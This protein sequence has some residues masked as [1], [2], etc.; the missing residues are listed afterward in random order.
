M[1]VVDIYSVRLE[2]EAARLESLNEILAPQERERAMRFRFAEHQREYIVCRGTLREVLA[3]YVEQKPAHIEFNYN[4]HGKPSVRDSQRSSEVRFNVSHSKGW[5]LLAVTRGSEVGIDIER[6]D[7]RFAADQIPER[8]FSPR[9]VAQLR[10]LPEDQQ[11]AAFF[12]CWTRKEA[13]IK[14][15]GLGLALALDSFDVSLGP[16]DPPALMRAGDW[17]LLDLSGP[18]LSGPDLSG[19]AFNV[20]PGYAAAVVAEGPAFS[21]VACPTPGAS[22]LLP[23]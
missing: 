19:K 16:D 20:P 9:E 3:P 15:R 13:Y 12:R 21:A 5:A 23:R 10:A 22:E 14:A 11:T 17:S 1:L 8:Y 18:G 6:V 2:A 4:R 7:S